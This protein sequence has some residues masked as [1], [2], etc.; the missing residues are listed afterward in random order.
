[1]RLDLIRFLGKINFIWTENRIR[2]RLCR[3]SLPMCWSGKGAEQRLAPHR[4]NPAI[5]CFHAGRNYHE[6]GKAG[7]LPFILDRKYKNLPCLKRPDFFQ[8][9][10]GETGGPPVRL[11]SYLER[12][13]NE[14]VARVKVNICTQYK[15]QPETGILKN[16]LSTTRV[17]L[18]LS[19]GSVHC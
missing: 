4:Y 9:S 15:F 11:K 13:E 3:V 5:P 17:H 18:R 1:V 6:N 2:Y 14:G 12:L 8:N 7:S 10:L 19:W 16:Y